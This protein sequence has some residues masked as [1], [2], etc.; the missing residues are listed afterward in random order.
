MHWIIGGTVQRLGHISFPV[1]ERERPPPAA[2]N[3][4]P[5]ATV[6]YQAVLIG[7]LQL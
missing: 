2:L 1:C 4:L 5:L 7:W 6:Q 3:I